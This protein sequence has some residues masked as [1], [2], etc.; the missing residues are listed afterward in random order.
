MTR[1]FSHPVATIAKGTVTAMRHP[2]RQPIRGPLGA[3]FDPF[4]PATST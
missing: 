1:V 4:D 3:G 2:R